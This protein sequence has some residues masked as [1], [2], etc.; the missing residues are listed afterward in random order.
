MIEDRKTSFL[1][2]LEQITAEDGS[3]ANIL[4]CSYDLTPL[5]GEVQVVENIQAALS[6]RASLLSGQSLICPEG[7]WIGKNWARI[8]SLSPTVQSAVITRQKYLELHQSTLQIKSTIDAASEKKLA[9]EKQTEALYKRW[10]ELREQRDSERRTLNDAQLQLEGM[11]ASQVH[12]KERRESLTQE[13][14][15]VAEQLQKLRQKHQENSQLITDIEDKVKQ[16]KATKDDLQKNNTHRLGKEQELREQLLQEHN[17]EHELQLQQQRNQFVQQ[18]AIDQLQRYKDEQDQI[19]ATIATRKQQILADANEI[20]VLQTNKLTCQKRSDEL[21]SQ[22]KQ[23]KVAIE[24]HNQQLT[25]VRKTQEQL[26]EK[27]DLIGKRLNEEK[28]QRNEVRLLP[29]K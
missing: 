7:L 18:N 12:R 14:H 13:H 6:Q 21:E 22:L 3:I 17:K 5:I 16:L 2:Q 29:K 28:L 23:S 4:G 9:L 20:E 1:L 27:I 26:A 19:S 10:Q 15:N 8:P 25:D 11:R 24:K